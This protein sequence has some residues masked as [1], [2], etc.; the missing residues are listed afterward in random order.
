MFSRPIG[1]TVF[2]Q[3]VI[4]LD[5]LNLCCVVI[6]W[7]AGQLLCFIHFLQEFDCDFDGNGGR[8]MMMMMMMM[9]VVVVVHVNS[10]SDD[11]DDHGDG[12]TMI[13]IY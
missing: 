4:K 7:I 11:L 5:H 3:I 6:T 12:M 1:I 13:I 10:K 9:I 8:L 2:V